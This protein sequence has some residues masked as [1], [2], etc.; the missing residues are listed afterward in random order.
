MAKQANRMMIGGFVVIAVAILA[1]SLVVFG[2]GRFFRKTNTYV[3]FFDE[4]IKGLSV[5]AP[6]LFQGVQV[7]S[8]SNIMIV[9]DFRQLQAHIPVFIQVE[10]DRFHV[11][12]DLRKSK[13]LRVTAQKLVDAGL[14]AQLAMQSFITGQLLVELDF[15]PNTPVR[16]RNLEK[17]YIELPTIPST[18]ARIA[19]TLEKIDLAALQHK[20]EA[21]LDGVARITN[22]PN[23]TAAVRDL[24]ETLASARKLINRVDRRFD[25]LAKN[26]QQTV[27]EVGRLATTFDSRVRELSGGLEKTLTIL[28]KT[29]SGLDKTMAGV[30]GV[31]SPDAPVVVEL[32]GALRQLAA[33]G[34]SIRELA[35][36]LEQQPESL[37]RGKQKAGGKQPC[38]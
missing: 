7:G 36:L 10:P 38:N 29:L 31:V 26:V 34:R 33:T 32:E 15:F 4:S 8:V 16:L 1:A 23:L 13:E 25:P 20:L 35:D 17:D 2:S 18:T 14:R 12:D 37:L 6:V 30:R 24:K 9:A 22:D 27:K 11:T 21:G 5:G 19:Q 28:D 3:L